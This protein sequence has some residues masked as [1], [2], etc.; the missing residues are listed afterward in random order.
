MLQEL[1]QQSC[2]ADDLKATEKPG[3][4]DYP[5]KGLFT[6]AWNLVCTLVGETR[7]E[8]LE[9]ILQY[10]DTLQLSNKN[11]YRAC[12]SSASIVFAHR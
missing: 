2:R 7:E 4:G 3:W 9:D 1:V 12:A 11:L 8:P 10:R 5:T 6:R